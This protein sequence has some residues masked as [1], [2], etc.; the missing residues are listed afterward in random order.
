MTHS[1]SDASDENVSFVY[2]NLQYS[3]TDSDI[4]AL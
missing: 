2:I 3:D 4:L 1:G